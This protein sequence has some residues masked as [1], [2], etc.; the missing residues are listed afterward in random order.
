MKLIVEQGSLR[1]ADPEMMAGREVSLVQPL[2]SIGR[3]GDNDLV[4]PEEGVSRHHARFERGPQGWL[5]TDLGSTNGTYVNGK[6]LPGHEATLLRPGDR[7]TIGGTVLSVRQEEEPAPGGAD[8]G[9][10][11]ARG[12]AR[13]TPALMIVGAVG[14]LVVLAGLVMLLVL[15]LKPAEGPPTPTAVD[16]MQQ[17]LTA[18]PMPTGL[19]QIVTAVVPLLPSGLPLPFFGGT[20]T[21]TPEAAVPGREIVGRSGP[22]TERW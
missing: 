19:D 13:P 12:A 22:K 9:H 4:L 17:M 2:V 7:V 21:P 10:R 1:S 5:L 15:V 18:I 8:E 6:R 16:S 20:P 14:L 3:G 11:V